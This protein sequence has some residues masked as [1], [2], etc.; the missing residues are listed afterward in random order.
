[1]EKDFNKKGLDTTEDFTD[2]MFKA[3]ARKGPKYIRK[4]KKYGAVSIFSFFIHYHSLYLLGHGIARAKSQ[5]IH[6]RTTGP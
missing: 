2:E 5:I 3:V 1:M 6:K 4:V